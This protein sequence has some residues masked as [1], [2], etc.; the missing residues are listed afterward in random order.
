[1]C[2]VELTAVRYPRILDNPLKCIPIKPYQSYFEAGAAMF[3]AVKSDYPNEFITEESY[4]YHIHVPGEVVVLLTD[5]H[6]IKL[7]EQGKDNWLLFSTPCKW[8]KLQSVNRNSLT[9]QLSFESK[10][11]KDIQFC[12]EDHSQVSSPPHLAGHQR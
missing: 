5:V 11:G 4:Q 1:S 12:N 3:N 6:L 8:T 10:R 2:C 7:V 9:V